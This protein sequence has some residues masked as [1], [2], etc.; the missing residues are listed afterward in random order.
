MKKFTPDEKFLL[1]AY[2]KSQ[3]QSGGSLDVYEIGKSIGQRETA[4]KNIVK[5]LAQANFLRKIGDLFEL[6]EHGKKFVEEYIIKY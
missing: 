2:K 3:D 4:I 5:L 6:T 1:A